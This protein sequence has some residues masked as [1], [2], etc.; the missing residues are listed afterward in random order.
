MRLETLTALALYKFVFQ[1]KFGAFISN[2]GIEELWSSDS[3]IFLQQILKESRNIM[4]PVI[5]TI[6][7]QSEY[8][9]DKNVINPGRGTWIKSIDELPNWLIKIVARHT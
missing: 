9:Q 1:V 7:V 8:H 2:K 3:T 6:T 4:N 5:L